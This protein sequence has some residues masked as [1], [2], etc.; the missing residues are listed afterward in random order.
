MTKVGAR[1][2]KDEEKYVVAPMLFVNDLC[3]NGWAL[4]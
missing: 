4:L 1:G 2:V 3:K